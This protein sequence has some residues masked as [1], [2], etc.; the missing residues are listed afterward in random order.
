MEII[1]IRPFILFLSM[2]IFP[3]LATACGWGPDFEYWFRRY[4]FIPIFEYSS[5]P[6][7]LFLYTYPCLGLF[8]DPYQNYGFESS[9]LI[10]DQINEERQKQANAM[11]GLRGAE[12]KRRCRTSLKALYGE[13]RESG[14]LA[15]KPGEKHI[16]AL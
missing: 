4:A 5:V 12:M 7:R 11:D 14:P 2:S 3:S 10:L 15:S 6:D 1:R 13:N 8:T 16:S 9:D